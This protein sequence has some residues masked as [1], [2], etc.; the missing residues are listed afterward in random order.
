[1]ALMWLKFESEAPRFF[2]LRLDNFH[3]SAYFPCWVLEHFKPH[4]GF[5]FYNG[6]PNGFQICFIINTACCFWWKYRSTWN[7]R[8]FFV[9][10]LAAINRFIKAEACNLK[11]WINECGVASMNVPTLWMWQSPMVS[12]P[13]SKSS[14]INPQAWKYVQY[15]SST[16]APACCLS[17]SLWEELGEHLQNGTPTICVFVLKTLMQLW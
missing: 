5:W 15:S 6:F 3:D 13:S 11:L 9:V 7:N 2:V 12:R 4:H 1:M 16:V 10:F 17:Q 8:L 14:K